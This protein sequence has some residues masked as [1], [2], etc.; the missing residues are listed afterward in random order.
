MSDAQTPPA[1]RCPHGNLPEQLCC[2]SL[3]LGPH[4]E[5]V[6]AEAETRMFAEALVARE[7]DNKLAVAL[8]AREAMREHRKG[9]PIAFQPRLRP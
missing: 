6:D 2:E 5:I 4:S 1:A 9:K 7:P 3:S 8:A